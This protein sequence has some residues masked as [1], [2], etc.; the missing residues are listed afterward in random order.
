MDFYL[1]SQQENGAW[2]QQY[3]LKMQPAGARTYEPAAYLPRATLWNSMLLL[4]F[5]QFTGDRKFLKGVPKAISWLEKVCLPISMSDNGKYTHS[6][7]IEPATNKPIFVHRKG[8]NVKY[9]YYYVDYDDKYLLGHM[10]GKGFLDIKSLK[11]EYELISAFTP[12][13][14]TKKSPLK[15]VIT[16]PGSVKKGYFALSRETEPEHRNTEDLVTKIISSLDD[17]NRWL[18]KHVMISNPFIGDGQSK[19]FTNKYAS[20]YVGDET[21]TS[22]YSDRTDTKYISTPEYIR[23]MKIL[24]NYITSVKIPHSTATKSGLK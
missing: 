19:D 8:S 15:M 4:K 22:P 16:K 14:A 11:D 21:D 10:Q 5:Y 20:T 23:N 1:I 12:D 17:Q 7:Y 6:L 2:A 9:G 3:N 24:I 13:M 18:V